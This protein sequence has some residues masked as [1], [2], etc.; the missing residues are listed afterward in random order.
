MLPS[1]RA[2]TLLLDELDDTRVPA[3]TRW[4]TRFHLHY[5]DKCHRYAAQ[6]RATAEALRALATPPSNTGIDAFRAWRTRA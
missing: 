4:A 3:L 1:C 2:A 6:H 5:C